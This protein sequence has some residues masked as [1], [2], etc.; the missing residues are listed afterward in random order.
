[1]SCRNDTIS[2]RSEPVDLLEVALCAATG[3]GD[4]HNRALDLLGAKII[5]LPHLLRVHMVDSDLFIEEGRKKEKKKICNKIQKM[6]VAI[7]KSQN[8][9]PSG[10]ESQKA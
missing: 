5:V 2:L 4:A 8:C 9:N 1:M 7:S 10:R 6:K 3:T